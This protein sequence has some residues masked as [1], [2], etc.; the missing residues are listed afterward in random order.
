M[1]RRFVLIAL[2]C[3]C[4]KKADGPAKKE[5]GGVAT[6]NLPISALA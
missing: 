6:P 1:M 5:D 4:G 2:L 3:A